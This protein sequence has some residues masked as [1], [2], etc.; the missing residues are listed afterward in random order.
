[1][2]KDTVVV[3]GNFT[4]VTYNYLYAAAD[5]ALRQ[6]V[7]KDDGCFYNCLYSI[8]MSAFCLEAYVNHIGMKHFPD[9]D[10]WAPTLDKLKR[11][12]EAK[13]IEIDYRR[14][15]F[16]GIKSANRLRNQLAHGRTKVVKVSY[17]EKLPARSTPERTKAPWQKKCTKTHA[18]LCLDDLKEVVTTIHEKYERGKIPLG[19]FGHGAFTKELR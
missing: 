7:A 15:P 14:R 2:R 18:K 17:T 6:A 3:S 10:E 5:F 19:V 13:G 16:S 8:V 1:M 12:A 9:W 4:V 11:V